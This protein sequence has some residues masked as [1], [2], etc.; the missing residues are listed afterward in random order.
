MYHLVDALEATLAAGTL[1]LH[2]H[3]YLYITLLYSLILLAP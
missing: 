3:Y 1:S 2:F